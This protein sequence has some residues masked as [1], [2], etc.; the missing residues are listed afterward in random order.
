MAIR[1]RKP[2]KHKSQLRSH[3]ALQE[4]R[5]ITVLMLLSLGW[6]ACMTDPCNSSWELGL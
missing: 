6:P 4:K 2:Q 3:V 1:L 5:H